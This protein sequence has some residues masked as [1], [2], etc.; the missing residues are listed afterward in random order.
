MS[1][2]PD[3]IHAQTIATLSQGFKMLA[4]G[5][6]QMTARIDAVKAIVCELHPEVAVRLE[7]KIRKDQSDTSK[8]FAE[9]QRMLE[10]LASNV[11]DQTH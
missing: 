8:Q 7:E 11:S 6:L 10:V 4:N 2:P 1:P 9:L 3:D 5:F